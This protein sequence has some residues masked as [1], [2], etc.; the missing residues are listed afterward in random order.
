LDLQRSLELAVSLAE[1]IHR[2]IFS[3]RLRIERI[4][5]TS[6][7]PRRLGD[8]TIPDE[9]RRHQ[10]Y[11]EWVPGTLF[12]VPDTSCAILHTLPFLLSISLS[13]CLVFSHPHR[14]LLHPE[15]PGNRTNNGF[16]D[17]NCE[18]RRDEHARSP[19]DTTRYSNTE[20]S[21]L[22]EARRKTL[23]IQH[24]RYPSYHGI[25]R[26]VNIPPNP[27]PFVETHGPIDCTWPHLCLFHP[28]ADRTLP[29]KL[30]MVVRSSQQT[31][32]TLSECVE[33]VENSS[34]RMCRH[35]EANSS[36]VRCDSFFAFI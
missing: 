19:H 31:S 24:R 5:D 26:F 23:P 8:L 22:G 33:I 27:D 28:A 17:P 10:Q 21:F 6:L 18:V 11:G 15:R 29:R 2:L 25:P 7:V 30:Q 13:Y 14:R 34:T 16:D 36:C 12:S 32:S 20:L 9:R 4:S 35:R 1:T 3:S